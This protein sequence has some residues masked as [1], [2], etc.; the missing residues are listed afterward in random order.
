MRPTRIREKKMKPFTLRKICFA[1]LVAG[2]I[3]FI[4]ACNDISTQGSIKPERWEYKGFFVVLST[5]DEG[6]TTVSRINGEY[7]GSWDSRPLFEV[8]FDSLG[9]EGWELVSVSTP[10]QYSSDYLFTFKRRVP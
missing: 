2:I 9:K 8:A 4:S 6:Q 5:N 3:L 1:L 10:V 7:Q